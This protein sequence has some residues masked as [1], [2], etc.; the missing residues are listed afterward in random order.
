[1]KVLTS[2]ELPASQGILI[3]FGLL[4]LGY[5]IGNIMG[6]VV[7]AAVALDEINLQTFMTL[8]DNLMSSERGW[9]AMVLGQ[10]AGSMI[11][12]IVPALF[13]WLVFEKRFFG[14]L[15]FRQTP[16]TPFLFFI[17]I[18][19]TLFAIPLIS[20]TGKLNE[21]MQLP[22]ALAGFENMLKT[23]EA[24]ATEMTKFMVSFTSFS[25]Y[26]VSMLIIAGI[27]GLG[28]ELFFRGML[29]RKIWYGTGNIHIGI[30]LSAAIFS[31]I[32]FQFYGFLP[33]MLLGAMFGY[34]YYWSGNLWVPIIGHIFN[35]GLSVTLMFASNNKWTDL[36]MENT[37]DVTPLT[38][39][40]SVTLTSIALYF[41]YK[42][43]KQNYH[44]LGNNS[45]N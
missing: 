26:V 4:L 9:W 45:K 38:V 42:H 11:I 31:A 33:R 20:W 28:E 39:A 16:N 19:T 13:Y 21:S 6:A 30:W 3:L 10:G 40:I 15:C 41:F 44:E 17:T 24:K 22:A 32:H 14:D 7:M 35:N 25:Q 5:V 43:H 29:Q 2:K 27:A 1:M 18:S 12:F 37:N 8:Q 23:L 34:L 36:D